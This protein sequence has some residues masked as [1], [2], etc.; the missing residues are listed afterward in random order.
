MSGP[1]NNYRLTQKQKTREE[2]LNLVGKYYTTSRNTVISSWHTSDLRQWAIEQ[3]LIKSDVEVKREELERLAH[4]KYDKFTQAA[5]PYIAWTDARLRGWLRAHSP[6]LDAVN[7][8]RTELISE[9]RK[10]YS[11]TQSYGESLKA[12][13]MSY[14]GL[15]LH[16]VDHLYAYLTGSAESVAQ[17]AQ[18]KAEE[19]GRSAD[20]ASSSAASAASSASSL[21]AKASHSAKQEL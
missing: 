9:V 14:V 20:A 3:N 19:L 4:E 11:A 15:G 7:K 2:L 18:Q 5:S 16:S 17:V 8:T 12:S 13:I 1:S 10:R 6:D 21:A